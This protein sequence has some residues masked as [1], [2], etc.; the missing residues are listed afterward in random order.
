MGEKLLFID[1]DLFLTL[2]ITLTLACDIRVVYEQAKIGFVFAQR[3]IVP[4]AASSFFLPRLIG[5]SRSLELFMTARVQKATAPSLNLLFSSFHPTPEATTAAGIAL[6]HE[7]AA[8]TSALSTALIKGMVW[9]GYNT[10]E[11]QHLLDSQAIHVSGNSSDSAEGV[12]AFKEK[13]PAVFKATIPAGLRQIGELY[14]WWSNPH[15]DYLPWSSY[16]KPKL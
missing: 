4:E 7:I 12:L 13:R 16:A 8:N 1:F 10:A 6:A 3:G 9:H 15:I 5:H 2:G 11:E 14:P